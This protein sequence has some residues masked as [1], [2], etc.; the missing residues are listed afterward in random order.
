MSSEIPAISTLRTFAGMCRNGAA[1]PWQEFYDRGYAPIL[2]AMADALELASSRA[3]N[4][5]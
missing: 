5:R 1:D 2:D 3:R 4:E